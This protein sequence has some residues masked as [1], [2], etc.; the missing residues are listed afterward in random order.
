MKLIRTHAIS[1]VSQQQNKLSRRIY[2]DKNPLQ[3]ETFADIYRQDGK[4]IIA[5]WISLIDKI[6]RKPNKK[7]IKKRQNKQK[8]ILIK[9]SFTYINRQ[10]LKEA[11]WPY[12]KAYFD[13][14]AI[15]DEKLEPLWADKIHPYDEKE[16]IEKY[17]AKTKTGFDI[18][19]RLYP[20]FITEEQNVKLNK[21]AAQKLAEKI[22]RHLYEK[23]LR[24]K[25]GQR[26]DIAHKS[27][28]IA[29]SIAPVALKKATDFTDA[30]AEYSQKEDIIATIYAEISKARYISLDIPMKNLRRHWHAVFP[31]C[32]NMAQA[33]EHK[34][35]LLELHEVIKNYYQRILKAN[36]KKKEKLLKILPKDMEQMITRLSCQSQNRDVNGLIRIGKLIHYELGLK[37][38]DKVDEPTK[39]LAQC[40][41]RHTDKQIENKQSEALLRIFHECISHASFNLRRWLD[42]Q[43][44]IKKDILSSKVIEQTT[45]ET[46]EMQERF[47]LIFPD[48]FALRNKKNEKTLSKAP[49]EHYPTI[50]TNHQKAI[51]QNKQKEISNL[52][53]YTSYV[54]TQLFHF[55]NHLPLINQDL[56]KN[57]SKSPFEGCYQ[58]DQQQLTLMVKE[59]LQGAQAEKYITQSDFEALIHMTKENLPILPLPAFKHLLKRAENIKKI[60]NQLPPNYNRQ[61]REKNPAI[62]AQY[63]CLKHIYEHG[64]KSYLIAQNPHKIIQQALKA[65][66]EAAQE[67]N[68]KEVA[69][70]AKAQKLIEGEVFDNIQRFFHRLFSLTA[71]EMAVSSTYHNNKKNAAEQA[72]YIENLKKDVVII[73][74]NDF[75]QQKFPHILKIQKNTSPQ[76][77][78]KPEDISLETSTTK[79]S[80]EAVS[81]F[82][83]FCHLVPVEALN[84]LYHQLSR[85]IIA[86]QAAGNST[87][88]EDYT[89]I[90]QILSLYIR[91]H[92]YKQ[93]HIDI[94]A[95]HIKDFY[96]EGVIQKLY[97]ENLH[98]ATENTAL[99]P[100][101]GLREFLRFGWPEPI[102]QHLIKHYQITMADYTQWEEQHKDIAQKQKRREELHEQWVNN[103]KPFSEKKKQEYKT[104]INHISQ[105]NFLQN[106][107]FLRDHI[108][109]YHLFMHIFSRF[110][111]YSHH[112]ER[113]CYFIA[114]AHAFLKKQTLTEA[115]GKQGAEDIQK[116][117][118]NQLSKCDIL[119]HHMNM[120]NLKTIR[121][122]FAHFNMFIGGENGDV[123]FN[124]ITYWINQARKL[125]AYDRKMKN[126]IVKAIKRLLTENNLDDIQWEMRE[127]ELQQFKAKAKT[128]RHLKSEDITEALLAQ[129]YVA[130]I[131]Y[132]FSSEE[133]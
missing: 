46:E 129:S 124:N 50:I 119:N 27:A 32:Y 78:Y 14:H 16:F 116:G 61:D 81:C 118:I 68:N 110:V 7:D 26:V 47:D 59:K 30:K 107:I 36:Y 4:L 100:Y 13:S 20:L 6:Y 44:R 92:D 57:L 105:H 23:S 102:K 104:L 130:S 9:N 31:N 38:W 74:F 35:K 87:N 112:F 132:A 73:A 11:C 18:K 120:D 72:L 55:K 70:T 53:K 125:M 51:K 122:D 106:K 94:K 24:D 42:P 89:Q 49:L 82:Y 39:W 97:P 5:T 99:I 62:M 8:H 10:A 79:A 95:C 1:K 40:T 19:G 45:L 25:Q 41:S 84:R 52:W 123:N 56:L 98:E 93:S 111:T 126:S 86:R 64:F 21:A 15:K 103:K 54:R 101:R 88:I 58:H 85:N 12:I 2:N 91:M 109:I 121:D 131:V 3:G 128:V 33:K 28:A 117:R 96:D 43:N 114:I 17:N 113:D 37:G 63:T 48:F 76:E 66:T 83:G 71:K 77:D 60:T 90:A 65:T 75:M 133:R 80:N 108:K 127:H 69:V 29:Q 34:P 115:Y 22:N 67:M